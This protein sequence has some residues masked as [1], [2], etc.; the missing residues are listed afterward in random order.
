VEGVG[1]LFE[2]PGRFID[3]IKGLNPLHPPVVDD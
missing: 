3:Y 1:D 2:A